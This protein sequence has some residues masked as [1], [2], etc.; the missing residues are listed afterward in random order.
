M[1]RKRRAMDAIEPAEIEFRQ[2]Q[3]HVV[4]QQLAKIEA[5]CMQIEEHCIKFSTSA[6]NLGMTFDPEL[7]MNLH[8]Q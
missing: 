7:G 1:H 8:V 3:I 2:D 6:K 5:E 4:M